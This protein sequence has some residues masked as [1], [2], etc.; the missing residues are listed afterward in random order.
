MQ[1]GTAK[2][3]EKGGP[4]FIGFSFY[5]GRVCRV[6]AGMNTGFVLLGGGNETQRPFLLILKVL[7]RMGWEGGGVVHAKI[8]TIQ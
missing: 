3:S 6:L 8:A 4:I 1:H 2:I 7:F 5:F